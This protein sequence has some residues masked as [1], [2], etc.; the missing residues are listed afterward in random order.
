VNPPEAAISNGITQQRN[1]SGTHH[2]LKKVMQSTTYLPRNA[3]VPHPAK[4]SVIITNS[5]AQGEV[6]C[7]WQ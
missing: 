1:I 3:R 7:A 4:N 5:R 6:W 2:E